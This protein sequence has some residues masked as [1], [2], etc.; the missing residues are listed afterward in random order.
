MPKKHLTRKV[1]DQHGK[2]DLKYGTASK[3]TYDHQSSRSACACASGQFEQNLCN[4]KQK[5][6]KKKKK[7]TRKAVLSSTGP[8]CDGFYRY[9]KLRKAFS[10]FYRRHSAFLEKI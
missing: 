7:K 9:F 1:L 10:K 4:I 8:A 2:K 3:K 6:K 5:K